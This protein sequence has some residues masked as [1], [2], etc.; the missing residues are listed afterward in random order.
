MP[1]AALIPPPQTYI[2]VKKLIVGF[3]PGTVGPPLRKSIRMALGI[4][5]EN[6]IRTSLC[7]AVLGTF[8]MKNL[9]CF[10]HALV[11]NTLAWNNKIGL[12]AYLVGVC[13]G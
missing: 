10:R 13:H 2:A 5:S 9:T 3:L 4:F 7:R 8:T 12:V 1:A 11:V 6:C